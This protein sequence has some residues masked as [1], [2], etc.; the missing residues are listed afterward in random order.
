LDVQVT[1]FGVRGSCPCAGEDYCRVGGNTSC[2]LVQVTGEQPLILDLGTGARGAGDALIPTLRAEGKPFRGNA[3]LTHL[4]FDHIL[5]LP[6][7]P[8]L[9]HG[10]SVLEI[11]GPAQ[12]G[13][14]LTEQLFALVRPPYFPV[15]LDALR[16][17]LCF[18]ELADDDL[19]VGTAKV[20]ARRVE[21]PGGALGYRVEVDGRSL[22]YVPDHQQPADGRVPDGVLELCSGVELVIHDAQY[23]DEELVHKQTWGHS[24]VGFAV[25]VAAE[26]G[27][28]ELALFHHDPF[29]AD[30]AVDRM[31]ESARRL[32][33]PLGLSVV[34]AQE[35]ATLSPGRHRTGR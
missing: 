15:P 32:A 35:G 14:G 11:H 20:R 31:L 5:G 30:D 34:A 12:P 16:A 10:D 19:A 8:P 23:T 4:H 17:R 9:R 3:L 29:H 6:F 26:A 24:T 7:Y 27:A 1:F 13:S 21:H 18:H 33:D 28:G 2:V 25:R 22:A